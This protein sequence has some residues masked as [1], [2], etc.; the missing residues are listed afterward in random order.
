MS[1]SIIVLFLAAALFFS[2]AQAQTAKEI[3]IK[4]DNAK[5]PADVTSEMTM[6]LVNKKGKEKVRRFKIIRMGEERQIMWFLEPA[7]V[8]GTSFLKIENKTGFDDMRLYLP[9]F[10]KVRRIAS[11]AK[12]ESFMGSDFTYEDMTTRKIN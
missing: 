8:K 2:H 12:S 5:E 1:H 7:D 10:K 6:K 9:A 11:S 4:A 3:M